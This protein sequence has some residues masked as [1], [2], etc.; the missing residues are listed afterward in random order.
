M[1]H[2]SYD[3]VNIRYMFQGSIA[4]PKPANWDVMD[5]QQ[6]LWWA[7]DILRDKSDSDLLNG[8]SEFTGTTVQVQGD[9]FDSAPLAL[10]LDLDKANNDDTDPVRVI[11]T[12]AWEDYW[13]ASER[14]PE[15]TEEYL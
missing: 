11:T 15:E 9:F 8:L 6:K 12:R 2:S 1:D 5:A 13:S 14:E 4:V 3:T 10:A 7:D